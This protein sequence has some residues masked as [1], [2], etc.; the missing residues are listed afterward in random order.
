MPRN[1]SQPVRRRGMTLL[2]LM[3]C[4]SIMALIALITG[5]ALH[6]LA[7]DPPR[8]FRASQTH[9]MLGELLTRIEQDLRASPTGAAA[10]LDDAGEQPGDLVIGHADGVIYYRIEQDRVVRRLRAASCGL[11]RQGDREEELSSWPIDRGQ[12]HWAVWK[13]D[14]VAYAVEVRT[15]VMMVHRSGRMPVLANARVFFLGGREGRP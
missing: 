2:E 4:I 11:R 1:R 15:A 5:P 8:A 14:Q 10:A 12:V 13:R 6:D 3:G 9:R 7:T